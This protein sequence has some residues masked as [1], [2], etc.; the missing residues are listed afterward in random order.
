MRAPSSPCVS[1]KLHCKC[2]H[3]TEGA[4][5]TLMSNAQRALP[6]CTEQHNLHTHAAR[7]CDYVRAVLLL[8]PMALSGTT[9]TRIAPS[10][11]LAWVHV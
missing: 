5:L 6:D 3:N 7:R 11:T 8:C 2:A 10:F 1:D 4:R 9:C